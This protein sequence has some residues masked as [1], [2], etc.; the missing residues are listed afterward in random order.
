MAGLEDPEVIDL[1]AED[2][3]GGRLLV[4]VV[5]RPWGADPAQPEQLRAKM[6]TYAQFILDGGLASQFPQPEASRVTIRLE[7]VTPPTPEIEAIVATARRRLERYD[8]GVAVK[9]NPRL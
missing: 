3:D 9:V 7:C 6:N 1:V 8:I 4:I 2:A 5:A